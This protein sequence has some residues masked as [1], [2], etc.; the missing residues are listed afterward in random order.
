M[1]GKYTNR[2]E[3]LIQLYTQWLGCIRTANLCQYVIFSTRAFGK[4][5]DH[6]RANRWRE[7]AR[8]GWG[9]WM[10][11]WW[12]A[13]SGR[14]FVFDSDGHTFDGGGYW[15]RHSLFALLDRS[16]RLG[17][18]GGRSESW[19]VIEK[20]NATLGFGLLSVGGRLLD[21]RFGLSIEFTL[22]SELS[23]YVSIKFEW[24][25]NFWCQSGTEV[26]FMR[27]RLLDAP[28]GEECGLDVDTLSVY[29]G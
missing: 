26:K 8:L 22:D 12:P 9:E 28:H 25:I 1:V 19:R 29:T 2:Y 6:L 3:K 20:D 16:R 24:D 23:S 11:G 27:G 18:G 5:M 14:A 7:R 4:K 21:P 10:R 13:G 17:L 15:S